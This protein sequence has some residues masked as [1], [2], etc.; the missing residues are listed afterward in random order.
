MEIVS[1]SMSERYCRTFLAVKHLAL[2]LSQG[3]LVSG[4][5]NMALSQSQAHVNIITP[6]RNS[7]ALH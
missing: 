2:P 4:R 6:N 1:P 7:N 3:T 5:W